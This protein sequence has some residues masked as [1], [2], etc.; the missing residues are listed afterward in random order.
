M[1][2]SGDFIKGVGL[3][4]EQVDIVMGF[5]FVGCDIGVI[6]VV[7][8]CELVGVFVVGNDGVNELEIIV[9][10]LDVQGYGGDC[11]LIDLFVVC[12]FGYYIGL[13]FE[14]ELIF[15]IFD[16]KGCLCQFGFVFGGGWYDDL[17]KW[18]I[19]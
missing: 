16:E 6:I 4:D 13:V 17:V 7:C 18:F 1:D 2:E 15:E 9:E 8:L 12:G 11:I 19:G 14:V 3:L 5:M 10:L